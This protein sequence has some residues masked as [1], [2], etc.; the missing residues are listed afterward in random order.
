V[1]KCVAGRSRVAVAYSGGLDSSVI[2]KCAIGRAEVVA[3]TASADGSKDR[4]SAAVGAALLGVELR[5]VHLSRELVAMELRGSGPVP[6]PTAMD[7]SLWCLFSAVSRAASEE[8]AQAILLGQLADELFGGYRK[9]SDVLEAAGAGAAA[10]AMARDEADYMTC[11]MGRDVGAC[12]RWTEPMLPFTAD[13]VRA[14]AR[15][16]PLT[17]KIRDGVRKAV[18]REAAKRLGVPDELA[19]APKKAAQYSSGI[20]KLVS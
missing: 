15:L 16:T 10:G 2:A 6:L 19:N 17:F 13:G 12:S 9:Y 18:L 11:G 1:E 7:R 5:G 3:V 14:A 4:E 20:Q 8:G